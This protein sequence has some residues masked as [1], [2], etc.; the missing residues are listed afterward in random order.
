VNDNLPYRLIDS[1]GGRRPSFWTGLSTDYF[2][3]KRWTTLVANEEQSTEECWLKPNSIT[4][5]GSKLVRSWAQTGSKLVGDQL[6]ASFEPA[7]N[8][9]A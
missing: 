6:R 1:S 5:S 2:R 3:C 9:L 7:S 8:Q 4:L